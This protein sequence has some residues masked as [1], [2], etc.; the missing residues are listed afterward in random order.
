M[1]KQHSQVMPLRKVRHL[2][3]SA[4]LSL[5][6]AVA[7]HAELCYGAE[8]KSGIACYLNVVFV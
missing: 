3:Y 6:T 5:S 2:T 7:S 8:Q 4:L 1:V